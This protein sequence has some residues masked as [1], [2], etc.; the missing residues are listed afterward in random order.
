MWFDAED[1]GRVFSGDGGVVGSSLV[2]AMVQER[3]KVAVPWVRSVHEK[4]LCTKTDTR[5]QACSGRSLQASYSR[6][7]FYVVDS[8]RIFA[9]R[10]GRRQHSTA[11][12][13]RS[14]VWFVCCF[15]RS[16]GAEGKKRNQET[17]SAEQWAMITAKSRGRLGCG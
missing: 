9:G 2:L 17:V 11:S 5:D 13:R 7:P 14:S 15:Q 8:R 10:P 6:A 4:G 16:T 1:N 3:K 12:G